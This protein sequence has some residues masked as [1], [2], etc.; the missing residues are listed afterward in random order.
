MSRRTYTDEEIADFQLRNHIHIGEELTITVSPYGK[1]FFST[2]ANEI[3]E[4]QAGYF[5]KVESEIAILRMTP[6]DMRKI[7]KFLEDTAK[8]L[9]TLNPDV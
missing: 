4:E 2:V 6:K 7:A 9:E 8:E 1:L 5:P 3:N